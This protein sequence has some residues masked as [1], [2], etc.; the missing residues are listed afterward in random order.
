MGLDPLAL[1]FRIRA[2]LPLLDDG[3]KGD[4]DS[5]NPYLTYYLAREREEELR[6]RAEV[7][8]LLAEVC[9]SRPRG[10]RVLSALARRSAR[11][12]QSVLP[13]RSRPVPAPEASVRPCGVAAS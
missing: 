9:A 12:L 7:Y 11:L 4:T 2:S 1:F 10:R 5:M 8:R 13:S 3:G 6:R